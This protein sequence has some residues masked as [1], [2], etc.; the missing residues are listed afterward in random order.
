MVFQN[1]EEA[2]RILEDTSVGVQVHQEA[3][4]FLADW[5]DYLEAESLVRALQ[6][7]DFGTRWK[8]AI[9]L[10]WIG[11]NAIPALLKAMVDP[12]RVGDL[13]LRSGVV[14]AI[15]SIQD[16]HLKAEFGP[17]LKALQGPAPDLA[18]MQ[19]GNRLLEKICPHAF[20]ECSLQN[21]R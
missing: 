2:I 16:Q 12:K 11:Q 1:V 15:R 4:Y 17:L 3:A 5:E 14:H 9:L 6:D 21:L 13:R 19:E 10:A 8:A 7:D 18:A 20:V